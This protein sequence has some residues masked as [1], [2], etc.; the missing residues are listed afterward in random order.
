MEFIFDALAPIPPKSSHELL[1][2]FPIPDFSTLKDWWTS[3]SL[4]EQSQVYKI[5]NPEI[6]NDLHEALTSAFLLFTLDSGFTDHSPIKWTEHKDNFEFVISRTYEFEFLHTEEILQSKISQLFSHFLFSFLLEPALCHPIAQDDCQTC[7]AKSLIA[8]KKDSISS[9]F[10]LLETSNA[11]QVIFNK[12]YS[13][14]FYLA[15]VQQALA[16]QYFTDIKSYSIQDL[17]HKLIA[18]SMLF[19]NNLYLFYAEKTNQLALCKP[20]EMDHLEYISQHQLV[21]HLANNRPQSPSTVTLLNANKLDGR[22][23]TMSTSTSASNLSGNSGSAKENFNLNSK[24]FIP[25]NNENTVLLQEILINNE[26]IVNNIE[27]MA[28]PEENVIHEYEGFQIGNLE[29]EFTEQDPLMIFSSENERNKKG[30]TYKSKTYFNPRHQPEYRASPINTTV[31][32]EN[33][34]SQNRPKYK[35]NNQNKGTKYFTKRMSEQPRYRKTNLQIAPTLSN[36]EFRSDIDYVQLILNH[37]RQK[38]QVISS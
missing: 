20:L 17:L 6:L 4:Q 11:Q 5:E 29:I 21:D 19:Q 12:E 13:L 38:E 36:G 35:G 2:S 14:D 27:N 30:I 23:Q 37:G 18:I 1:S 31:Y 33:Y 7:S 9:F 22:I 15:F 34:D 25:A 3:L 16:R 24:P 10:N 28:P 32:K 8:I 26:I